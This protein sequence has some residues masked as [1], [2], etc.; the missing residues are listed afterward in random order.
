MEGNRLPLDGHADGNQMDRGIHAGAGGN[1]KHQPVFHEGVVQRSQRAIALLGSRGD[2]FFQIAV[3][4]AEG[5]GQARRLDAFGKVAEVGQ[6]GAQPPV[7]ED[8]PAGP[9]DRQRRAFRQG[10][11][12]HGFGQRRKAL[13]FQRA[14]A[15]VTPGLDLA[16]RQPVCPK[17]LDP[18]AA[19]RIEPGQVGARQARRGLVEGAGEGEIHVLVLCHIHPVP[20]AAAAPVNSA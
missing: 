18:L 7:H 1:A 2:Q 16:I 4:A 11:Q 10:V 19:Q 8:N 13:L 6:I 17:C 3:L 14:Y 20:Q 9:V 15:G 12:R 5:L